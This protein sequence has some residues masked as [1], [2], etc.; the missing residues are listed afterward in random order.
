MLFLL[1]YDDYAVMVIFTMQFASCLPITHSCNPSQ[2]SREES[3]PSLSLSENFVF[4]S[5]LV[6]SFRTLIDGFQYLTNQW[7][8]VPYFE[9]CADGCCSKA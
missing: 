8:R 6:V 9:F 2:N 7:C 1:R 5:H 3:D 4:L